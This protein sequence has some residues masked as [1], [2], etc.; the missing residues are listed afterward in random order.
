MTN[1][2]FILYTSK[3]IIIIGIWMIQVH[4]NTIKKSVKRLIVYVLQTFSY[5]VNLRQII[6]TNL[7][8]ASNA[9]INSRTE[10]KPCLSQ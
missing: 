1:P 5:S 3:D 7:T 6:S 4:E 9:P 8:Y 2:R 10:E